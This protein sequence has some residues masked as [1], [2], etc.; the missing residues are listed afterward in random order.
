M[1]LVCN[2]YVTTRCNAKCAFCDIWQDNGQH[3][4]TQ[5]VLRNLKQLPSAGVRIIDF[6]GGEPLLHRDLPRFLETARRMGLQTTVTTNG[7]LYP[8]RAR[9]LQ[10]LVDLLHLSIDGATA[11]VHDRYRSVPCFDS[12]MESIDVALSLGERPDL[13]FTATAKN[14]RE[15]EPLI[16]LARSKGLIQIVNPVFESGGDLTLNSRQLEKLERACKAP[17]VYINGGVLKLMKEGGNDP[18]HPRCKA[19]SATLVISP[20]NKI[21]L[22]C[23]HHADAKI[24]IDGTLAEALQH[25]KRQ[26]ALQSQGR[27]EYCRGC[28]IN[29]YLAPSLPYRFDKYLA[30]FLPWMAKYLYYKHFA[31]LTTRSSSHVT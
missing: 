31:K 23:F 19:V 25:P 2:Y 4:D 11:E 27:Q 18:D 6:T 9:Q 5:E 22:P 10:G 20:D 8:K 12:V 26:K 1:P 15:I 14:Y 13:L 28:T 3:A 29:C 17:Y 16:A 7:L 21:L 24:T 30:N